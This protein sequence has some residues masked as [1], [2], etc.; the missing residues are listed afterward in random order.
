MSERKQGGVPAYAVTEMARINASM[1][2]PED[3]LRALVQ[4]YRNEAEVIH[5]SR[6]GGFHEGSSW[7][8]CIS[9]PCARMRA[10]IEKAEAA[11][12]APPVAGAGHDVRGH[13]PYHEYGHPTDHSH[14]PVEVGEDGE[15]RSLAYAALGEA[16]RHAGMLRTESVTIQ[17]PLARYLLAALRSTAPALDVEPWQRTVLEDAA[18][19]G[20]VGARSWLAA[21]AAPPV[22]GPLP[23]P[24]FDG[25]HTPVAN[26]TAP[27]V[28]GAEVEAAWDDLFVN[29]AGFYTEE[30]QRRVVAR[31]RP[32]IEAALRSAA[33]ALDE[34][35]T[36]SLVD[37]DVAMVRW[38]DGIVRSET[39]GKKVYVALEGASG[40]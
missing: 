5:Y 33:P 11:L 24:D 30:A 26:R 28:T 15:E 2:T 10:A 32:H 25:F 34:L 29:L 1:T 16:I 9:I 17:A 40:G 35:G 38:K 19:A 14:P 13:F 4:D 39:L 36:V 37:I 31:H 18:E 20:I 27:P 8:L 12:A 7:R 22:A 3:P 21:L 6:E 23:E